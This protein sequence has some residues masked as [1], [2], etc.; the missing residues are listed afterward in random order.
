MNSTIYF[1]HI[2][3]TGGTALEHAML[4]YRKLMLTNGETTNIFK[5]RKNTKRFSNI[6]VSNQNKSTILLCSHQ[7]CITDIHVGDKIVLLVRDPISRF[8]SA[9]YHGKRI[10]SKSKKAK[11]IFSHFDT[12]NQLAASQANPYCNTHKIALSAL[13]G[14]GHASRASF[15]YKNIE[16]F[17][18]RVDDVLFIGFTETLDSDF[19]KLK[20]IL[21]IPDEITLPEEYTQANKGPTYVTDEQKTIYEPGLTFLKEWYKQD[22]KFV[23]MCREIMASRAR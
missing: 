19:K 15:W 1:L 14:L 7:S 6:P 21:H 4:N 5:Y 3:K 16:Y 8:V 12:P 2:G 20:K 10:L 17:K 18:S 11:Q 13:K 22:I 23:N 9:F